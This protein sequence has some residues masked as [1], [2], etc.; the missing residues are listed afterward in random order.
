[1]FQASKIRKFPCVHVL[2]GPGDL[3]RVA[4]L[5]MA[6]LPFY[7]PFKVRT[8]FKRIVNTPFY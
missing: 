2:E 8:R 1:M 5:V 4:Y 3:V 6:G 7:Y